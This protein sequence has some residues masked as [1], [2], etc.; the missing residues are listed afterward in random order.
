MTHTTL[1]ACDAPAIQTLDESFCINAKEKCR[2]Y[3]LCDCRGSAKKLRQDLCRCRVKYFTIDIR[4]LCNLFPLH[5]TQFVCK[6]AECLSTSL[7]INMI[8]DSPGES[9]VVG[10]PTRFRK[11]LK[12]NHREWVCHFCLSRMQ[13]TADKRGRNFALADSKDTRDISPL[14]PGLRKPVRKEIT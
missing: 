4:I 12:G 9:P 7:E 1:I 10:I 13:V 2:I 3:R 11:E 8:L 6:R 5:T 14:G